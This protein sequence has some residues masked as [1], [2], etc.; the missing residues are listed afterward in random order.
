MPRRLSPYARP[1]AFPLSDAQRTPSP[2]ANPDSQD[3]CESYPSSSPHTHLRTLRESPSLSAD[4][5]SP[6]NKVSY[7]RTPAPYADPP[8]HAASTLRWC[9]IAALSPALLLALST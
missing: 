5:P 9:L 1:S 7:R 6:E 3:S 4:S 8:I 2:A